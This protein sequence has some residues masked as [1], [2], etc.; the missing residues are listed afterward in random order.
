MGRRPQTNIFLRMA[1]CGYICEKC[2]KYETCAELHRFHILYISREC[3][4]IIELSHA[5]EG[6][7]FKHFVGSILE[8]LVKGNLLS[9]AQLYKGAILM[10]MLLL[11]DV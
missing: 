3:N 8:V 2:T 7:V 4:H 11:C 9:I 1:L 10:H 6:C 5:E